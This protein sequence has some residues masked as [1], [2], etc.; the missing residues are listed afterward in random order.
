LQNYAVCSVEE[1]AV[2][3][4]LLTA[5]DAEIGGIEMKDAQPEPAIYVVV[6]HCCATSYGNCSQMHGVPTEPEH[7]PRVLVAQAITHDEKR[8]KE[9]R[10][11]WS[12]YQAEVQVLSEGLLERLN[13]DSAKWVRAAVASGR[14]HPNY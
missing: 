6:R 7:D 4:K 9:I 14:V 1:Q 3:D 10:K 2:V 13:P 11:N 8:A 5:F 12:T